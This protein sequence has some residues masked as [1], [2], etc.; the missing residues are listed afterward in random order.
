M[1]TLEFMLFL[2]MAG[3]RETFNY[4]HSDK[5]V[6]QERKELE[7]ETLFCVSKNNELVFAQTVARYTKLNDS[8]IAFQSF[9]VPHLYPE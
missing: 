8:R 1:N 9:I 2:F 6:E 4:P 7:T 5:L 3:L